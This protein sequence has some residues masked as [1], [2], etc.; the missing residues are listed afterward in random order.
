MSMWQN[1]EE[2]PN[3]AKKENT[4]N[5]TKGKEVSFKIYLFNT[6]TYCY[7]NNKVHEYCIAYYYNNSDKV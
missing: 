5:E 3:A 1:K 2:K 6:K 7:N 4:K